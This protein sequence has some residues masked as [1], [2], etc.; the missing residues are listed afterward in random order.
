MLKGVEP[1]MN[2]WQ[3]C[4]SSG[5]TWI[6]YE[7]NCQRSKLTCGFASKQSGLWQNGNFLFITKNSSLKKPSEKR[8]FYWDTVVRI[9][10]FRKMHVQRR[11]HNFF[12]TESAA[13][14]CEMYF[15]QVAVMKK[16]IQTTETLRFFEM[17]GFHR[18][19]VLLTRMFFK[20][21]SNLHPD[22]DSSLRLFPKFACFTSRSAT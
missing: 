11:I 3:Y 10:L 9:K 21:A 17:P 13:Q 19:T 6:W 18:D 15:L 2:R 14:V 16:Y 12:T 20:P 1:K 5:C 4:F 22:P 7:K 8:C